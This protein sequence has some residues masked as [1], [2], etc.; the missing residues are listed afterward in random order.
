[1]RRCSSTNTLLYATCGLKA[2]DLTEGWKRKQSRSA[3]RS[4]ED[5]SWT[6]FPTRCKP[7]NTTI[8][9]EWLENQLR[10]A[11]CEQGWVELDRPFYNVWPVTVSLAKSVALNLPFSSVTF[12]FE[13]LVL[14]FAVGQEPHSVGC[15]MMRW[16]KTR[17]L[18]TLD[19]HRT[20]KWQG[21]AILL[22]HALSTGRMRRGLA[23]GS[24]AFGIGNSRFCEHI[25][26]PRFLADLNSPTFRLVLIRA[27]NFHFA[28]GQRR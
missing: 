8:E 25:E 17:R 5:T 13:F 20:N 23:N 28:V 26:T 24:V 27:V 18:F 2:G 7:R 14:R 10:Q 12:P 19:C 16:E 22:Q 3:P 11:R 15:V 21:E 4:S 6:H 1:M 9:K